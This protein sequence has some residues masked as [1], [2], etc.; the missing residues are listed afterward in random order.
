MQSFEIIKG[1]GGVRKAGSQD[2]GSGMVFYLPTAN[3]SALSDEQKRCVVAAASDVDAIYPKDSANKD[4]LLIGY[5]LSEVF[6]INQ[7]AK[8]FVCVIASSGDADL[9]EVT[10]VQD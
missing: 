6:R 1:Q 2:G 5:H 10:S 9:S 8:V 3:M 7:S 4:V